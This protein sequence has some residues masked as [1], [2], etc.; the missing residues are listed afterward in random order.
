[1]QTLNHQRGMTLISWVIVIAIV[2]FLANILFTLGPVYIEHYNVMN[3]LKGLPE[4]KDLNIDS[5]NADS[6]IKDALLKRL[7]VNMAAD[8][9]FTLKTK[10]VSGGLEV[11]MT[12]DKQVHMM[13]NVD[14]LVHFSDSVVIPKT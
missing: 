4:T 12:Y 14:A 10:R 8:I 5:V 6:K 7:R 2:I 11:N 1:M 3:A 9:P 13:G